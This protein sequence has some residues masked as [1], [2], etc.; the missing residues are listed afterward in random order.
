MPCPFSLFWI[1]IMAKSG[2]CPIK[3]FSALLVATIFSFGPILAQE[4]PEEAAV[5]NFYY[6]E[7]AG[8]DT[9]SVQACFH[10]SD[11]TSKL[12]CPVVA[13]VSQR[14]IE[15]FLTMFLNEAEGYMQSPR[16]ARGIKNFF[17]GKGGSVLIA[18]YAIA[19]KKTPLTSIVGISGISVLKRYAG[20]VVEEYKNTY[21]I[22]Q[23]LREQI[24]A[25]VVGQTPEDREEILQVFG[26]F[27]D[28]YGTEFKSK[29]SA[30][31][32]GIEGP[33]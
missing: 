28:Q 6:L 17:I 4:N 23:A 32:D 22:G 31:L 11:Q 7:D 13:E 14:D 15:V 18:F 16:I 19:A 8:D 33:S 26:N 10:T 24:R 5:P 20:P 2:V 29:P 9:F 12:D 1:L 3:Y 30:E 21:R 25:G 27:L